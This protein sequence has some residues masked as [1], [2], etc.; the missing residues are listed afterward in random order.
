MDDGRHL[1]CGS[2]S[3]ADKVREARPAVRSSL[4]GRS[5]A[6][7]QKFYEENKAKDDEKRGVILHCVRES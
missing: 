1:T 3:P 4:V 6:T 7:T 5:R 2:S